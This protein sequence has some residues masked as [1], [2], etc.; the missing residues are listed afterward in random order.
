MSKEKID[1]FF[2]TIDL[3][4]DT[5]YLPRMFDHLYAKRIP[6]YCLDDPE[7]IRNGG[8]MLILA[9]DMENSG[10]F[11]A[12][13]VAKVLGGAEAGSLPCIYTS[14]PSIYVNYSTEE[15][16]GYPLDF[17]FLTIC[18]EIITEEPDD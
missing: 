17:E 6:V 2:L 8:L 3:V 10:R 13:A 16:I 1:A 7:T 14:A 15:R 4:N 11:I 18:D 9:N 5:E 12:D